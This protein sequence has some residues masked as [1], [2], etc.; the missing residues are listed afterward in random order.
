[1]KIPVGVSNRHIHLSSEDI[2]AL[3]DCDLTNYRDLKQP[4]QFAAEQKLDLLGP[5][6]RINNVRVLGPA[7]PQSQLEISKNDA[8]ALGIDPPVRDSGNIKNS[9][10]LTLVGPA[11]Q[12][13]LE[14]GVIIAHRHIHMPREVAEREGLKDKT[15][16]SVRTD[17]LRSLTFHQVLLRVSDKFALEFHV[18]TDEANA[19]LLKTGDTVILET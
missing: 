8:V 10:G 5:K 1:M 19:A 4:G 6:G 9:P 15:M 13:E 18:D 3:F 12:V 11:G 16:V 14:E 7:R 17:G 2:I